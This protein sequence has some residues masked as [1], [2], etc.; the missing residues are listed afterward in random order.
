MMQNSVFT[1]FIDGLRPI[2]KLTVDKWADKNRVLT[3]ASAAT[4]GLWSTNMTPYLRKVMACLSPT[5]E[6]QEIILAKGVQLGLTES[7]LNMVGAWI[8][9]DPCPIMYV[10]PTIDMA[11]GIGKDR[12][13]PMIE[14]CKSLR[15]KIRPARERDS[16]NT[17]KVKRFPGGMLILS[18]A[19]SAASLRSRPVRCL[20]FDEVDA[21]DADVDG[22][23][24]PIE[25]AKKRTST[26]MNRKIYMLSTPAL[27][28]TSA[29]WREYLN[30]D[31]QRYFVACK[32]C[33]LMQ[34]L[35]PNRLKWDFRNYETVHYQCAGCDA[36]WKNSDKKEFLKDKEMGGVA[37]WMPT[38][39]HHDKKRIGFHLS[40]LY[41]PWYTWEEIAR[42]IDNAEEANDD[43]L[44][45]TIV[46]TIY[47]E[48]Y[49]EASEAP[50][51]M[52]LMNRAKSD[53]IKQDTVS[54]DIYYA[55]VGV[56]VQ[57]N[58]LEYEIVGWGKNKISQS[59]RYGVIMGD[60]QQDEVW[61]QLAEIENLRWKRPDGGEVVI[62]MGAI[63]TGYLANE[64]YNFV[65]MR[66]NNKWMCIKGYDRGEKI[67]YNKSVVDIER[68]G[69]KVG[70]TELFSISTPLLKSEL[71]GWLKS[72]IREDGSYPAGYCKFPEDYL[73]NYYRGLTAEVQV[74]SKNKRG[75][76]VVEWKKNYDRNEPLDCRCY[77]RAA[78]Y[79]IKQD[80]F[81][82]ETFF[83]ILNREEPEPKKKSR[84][85]FGE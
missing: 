12:I 2:E 71:Y 17:N 25:L 21:A 56:D 82:D 76:T 50:D 58:R 11:E 75:Y 20:I 6:Y 80:E 78:G 46:N 83:W 43:N 19:N 5:S 53:G 36:K 48:P 7:G 30:T 39:E 52:R 8:D 44:R 49:D 61:N 69:M 9:L 35:E 63:D 27:K 14:N 42:D 84:R 13:T 85:K 68:R 32:E 60:P 74:L 67:I 70:Q 24:S 66:Q 72:E 37:Q 22:E 28:S 54:N 51:F 10:M 41:S 73:E 31:Q 33:G 34:Y 16:G 45:K 47:G 55:T 62:L 15:K 18:G 40:A 81:T 38:A 4:P 77:A 64:V 57:K 23:G 1:S 3:S 79:R 59:I 26:F 65:R 29:I